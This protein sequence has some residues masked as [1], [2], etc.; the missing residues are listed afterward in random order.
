MFIA[1]LA[2]QQMFAAILALQQMFT[3][4]LALKQMF[5]AILALLIS[6]YIFVHWISRHSMT[7]KRAQ[8]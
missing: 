4:I 8:S 1:I 6:A 3:A 7:L 2:L 5:A